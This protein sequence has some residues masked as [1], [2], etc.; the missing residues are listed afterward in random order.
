MNGW[1]SLI[2]SRTHPWNI[3]KKEGYNLGISMLRISHQV[4]VPS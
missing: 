2:E 1:I 3:L 4:M